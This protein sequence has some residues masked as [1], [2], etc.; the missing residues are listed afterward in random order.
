MPIWG[1]SAGS[2]L[3][4]ELLIAWYEALMG[5]YL[6]PRKPCL[7]KCAD[8]LCVLNAPS[9][10]YSLPQSQRKTL[11]SEMFVS[12]KRSRCKPLLEVAVLPESSAALL[13]RLCVMLSTM[14]VSIMMD[15]GICLAVRRFLLVCANS[16]RWSMRSLASLK[17][18]KWF[19]A[20]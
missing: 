12:S 4:L 8:R 14:L 10:L 1:T 2:S 3:V 15:S 18:Q 11:S 16:L 17:T 6:L 13:R 7:P 20:I 19:L 9:E 5:E